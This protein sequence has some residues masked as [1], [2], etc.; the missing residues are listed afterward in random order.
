MTLRN[1]I[2]RNI[3]E[4]FVSAHK[5]IITG[6]RLVGPMLLMDYIQSNHGTVLTKQLQDNEISL[7][8]Q[9]DPNTPIAVLFTRIE[10]Y[11]LFA[12]AGK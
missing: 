12:K 1:L 7:G 8:A 6:F 10:D 3:E 11:R 2:T 4:Y 9:W 5:N